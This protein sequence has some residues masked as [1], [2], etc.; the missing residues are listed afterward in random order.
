MTSAL[1]ARPLP[2]LFAIALFVLGPMPHAAEPPA[3]AASAPPSAGLMANVTA[4]IG[5]AACDYQSQCH[6]VG[7]GAKACGGPSGYLAW[8][9]KKTDPNAL[10]AAAEA[11]SQAQTDENKARGLASDCMVTPMPT[12]VCRPRA[13]D[14]KK[15]CQL[16]QGG[17][18][19]AI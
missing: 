15:V 6:A 4:L 7:V 10:Q 3:A 19:S 18:S 9:D 2:H 12:A 16:G 14:Q 8:S 11:H 17:A 1:I 13:V 5:D